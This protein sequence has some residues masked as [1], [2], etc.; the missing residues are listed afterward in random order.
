MK[1]GVEFNKSA[2]EKDF[3]RLS[4]KLE[5][6]FDRLMSMPVH[7]LDRSFKWNSLYAVCDNL[8]E[9]LPKDQQMVIGGLVLVFDQNGEFQ[10]NQ[11]N[12]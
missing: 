1:A 6:N 2:D 11:N 9:K 10:Y 3:L 7:A 4:A 12:M 8:S 5:E